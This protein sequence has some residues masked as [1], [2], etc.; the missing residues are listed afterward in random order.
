[1]FWGQR[2]CFALWHL[3]NLTPWCFPPACL[4][5]RQTQ[6]GTRCKTYKKVI[7]FWPNY[8]K[9]DALVS[10]AVRKTQIDHG[11]FWNTKQ[12]CLKTKPWFQ[13]SSN[14]AMGW[15]VHD[16]LHPEC[17][18]VTWHLRELCCYETQLW[19]PEDACLLPGRNRGSVRGW[20]MGETGGNIV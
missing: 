3:V 19:R 2:G 10:P 14:K 18:V 15:C 8:Q 20:L 17:A 11:V 12:H 13:T 7:V 16:I 1:M 5:T 9:Q 4:A 6:S